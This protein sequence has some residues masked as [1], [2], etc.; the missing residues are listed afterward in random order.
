MRKCFFKKLLSMIF[1]CLLLACA[2]CGKKEAEPT[3]ARTFAYETSPDWAHP[4]EDV[5][6][7]YEE[8]VTQETLSSFPEDLSSVEAWY[9]DYGFVEYTRPNPWGLTLMM[10]D[11]F[12]HRFERHQAT[13]RTLS[14]EQVT[15]CFP[16]KLNPE[17][18]GHGYP[19]EHVAIDTFTSMKVQTLDEEMVKELEEKWEYDSYGDPI[20]FYD[21]TYTMG[22]HEEYFSEMDFR[23]R[24]WKGRQ[25][26]ILFNEGLASTD[27]VTEYWVD[28][29]DGY[30]YVLTNSVDPMVYKWKRLR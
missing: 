13:I 26:L 6:K 10:D 17:V 1:V 2:S 9:G 5:D 4:G 19:Y 29:G 11:A 15:D 22:G 14:F 20:D 30:V 8:K 3:E 18:Y 7:L 12:Q 21:S 25:M 24:D 23:I 27:K 16:G 28:A